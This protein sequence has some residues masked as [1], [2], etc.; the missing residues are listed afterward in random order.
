MKNMRVVLDHAKVQPQC[1]VIVCGCQGIS[2]LLMANGC[3]HVAG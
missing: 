3:C 2:V 1:K